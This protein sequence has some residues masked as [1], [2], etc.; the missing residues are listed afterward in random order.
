MCQ[1][2]FQVLLHTVA[3]LTQTT[4]IQGVYYYYHFIDEETKSED[5]PHAVQQLRL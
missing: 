4:V 1:A 2:L 3:H 5:F